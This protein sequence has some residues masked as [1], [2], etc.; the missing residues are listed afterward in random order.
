MPKEK[1]SPT[2]ERGFSLTKLYTKHRQLM[3]EIAQGRTVAKAAKI[4]GMA[5]ATAHQV[6]QCELFKLEMDKM[7]AQID[8]KCVDAIARRINHSGDLEYDARTV[9]DRAA[10]KSAEKLEEL[11]EDPEVKPEVQMRSAVHIL[12]RTKYKAPEQIEHSV[13]IETTQEFIN[14]LNTA[15]ADMKEKGLSKKSS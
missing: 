4:I 1:A 5:P 14:M 6:T 9:L 7:Q 11:V 10:V 8:A 2:D 15:R 3:R 13:K 12:D